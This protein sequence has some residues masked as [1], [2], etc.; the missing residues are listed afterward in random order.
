MTTSVE[1]IIS[2][3]DG[4][5]EA[6]AARQASVGVQPQELVLAMLLPFARQVL[7]E[8]SADDLDA[9]IA[10]TFRVAAG[11]LSDNTRAVLFVP[12]V[13]SWWCHVDPLNLDD[14]TGCV[15]VDLEGE[16]G[17]PE[18]NVTRVLRESLGALGAVSPALPIPHPVRGDDGDR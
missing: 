5:E 9:G 2:V 18:L 3:L 8:A 17:D 13:G 14:P 1:K 10:N 12:G 4:L 11:L 7:S 15:H 6:L 16:A